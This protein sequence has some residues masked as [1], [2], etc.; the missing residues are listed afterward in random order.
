VRWE[1]EDFLQGDGLPTGS[2][3]YE[4][5]QFSLRCGFVTASGVATL[6][7]LV[8]DTTAV[9]RRKSASGFA[10]KET[11]PGYPG[12]SG[13]STRCELRQLAVRGGRSADAGN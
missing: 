5:A 4:E 3:R 13:W 7:R 2:L 11:C 9:R 8:C 6:L 10:S 12:I 1:F